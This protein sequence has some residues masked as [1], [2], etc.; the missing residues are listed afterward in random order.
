MDDATSRREYR[1][2]DV[3]EQEYGSDVVA[4]L[5]TAYGFEY[6]VFNPGASFRGLE[7]S[8]VNYADG[9]EVIEAMNEGTAVAIAHGLAKA[10]GNPAACILHDVVGTLNG[11]MGLYNAY[12]DRV[13]LLVLSGTGP[14]RKSSRRPW[15]EWIH[16]APDQG[17]LVREYTK[18]DD[19]PVHV[20]GV[21]ESLLRA[22]RIADTPPKGP[23]Y[24]TVDVDV[25]EGEL[26]EPLAM[27]DLGAFEPPSLQAPDPDALARAADHLVEA[28]MPV[29]LTDT[30]GDSQA[31]V[32]ALVDLAEAL[33]MPVVERFH[34]RYNFPNTHPMA[35]E[36]ADVVAEADLVLALDVWSVDNWLGETEDPHADLDDVVD[37]EF[38]LV[39]VGTHDIEIASVTADYNAVRPTDIAMLASTEIA[40]PALRDA[41]AERLEADSTAR[42]R[43]GERFDRLAE[44]HDTQRREWKQTAEECWDE[45]PIS[46]PRLAAEVGDVV[47]GD[48]WTLVNGRFRGWAHRLWEIDEYGAYVGGNSGGAGIGYGIGAAIGAG[49]AA[50]DRGRLPVNFQSDGDLMSNLGALWTIGHYGI[51]L[52]TV[53]HNNGTLYNST[54]HRME[55]AAHRG[56]DASFERALVGTGLRDPRPDYAAIAEA[57]DINGF[58]PVREPDDLRPALEAGW[59]AVANGNPALVDVIAQPR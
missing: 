45:T 23:T 27:P 4:D 31:A 18:W 38:T 16:T 6:V 8:L 55:L 49:L 25:Q 2:V 15:I 24:V 52:L 59:E 44:V 56:R 37:G 10:T 40:V 58:G 39:D 33:G 21:V 35:L 51:P 43:A 3:S 32:D 57:H 41:V 5:L 47:A 30:V 1:A 36:G 54:N 20:D 26:G 11:A 46:V 7:E 19:Q 34:N 29:V 9:P 28:E 12:Y 53:V 17:D 48:D 22:H 13:P 14:V 50:V 42:V